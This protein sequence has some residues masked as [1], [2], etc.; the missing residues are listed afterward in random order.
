MPIGTDID[1]NVPFNQSDV[2]RGLF[3]SIDIKCS[4]SGY[5]VNVAGTYDEWMLFVGF[6][7]EITFALKNDTPLVL[8]EHS[9]IFERTVCVEPYV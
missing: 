9:R 7:L 6:D 2:N 8:V 5:Y 1:I 4:T 3:V